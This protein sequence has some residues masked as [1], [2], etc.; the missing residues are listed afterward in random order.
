MWMSL[1]EQTDTLAAA[2]LA[3]A[4]LLVGAILENPNLRQSN[5]TANVTGM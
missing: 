3:P 5:E 2:S 1:N 4:R